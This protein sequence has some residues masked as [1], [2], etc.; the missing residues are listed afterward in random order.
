[1][2]RMRV[3]LIV[4]SGL[5]MMVGIVSVYSVKARESY[6]TE[7]EVQVFY[8]NIEVV[9]DPDSLS[10][11]VN[12][13]YSL[14]ADYEPKDLVLLEVPLYSQGTA[15]ETNY[16]RKEAAGALKELFTAANEEGHELIARSGYRSYETQVVLYEKY[17]EQDGIEAADMYS[18]RPG[19]S[20]HQTGLTVDITSDSVHGGLTEQFGETSEGQWVADNAHKFGFIVRYPQERVEA[21]G[22]QYEP[23][24]LRYVGVDTAT[25]IYDDQLILEDYVLGVM[26]QT[27]FI[28]E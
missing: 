11:L 27:S 20:E 6:I 14:P 13:N 25:A 1:M 21:T 3:F 8:Q 28:W 18:A 19:H 15:N 10:V 26:K 7:Q 5:F 17:V 4:M 23:W 16:L 24:H 22:Y 12:K 9:E 2:N